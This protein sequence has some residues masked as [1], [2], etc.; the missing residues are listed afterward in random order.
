V[1]SFSVSTICVNLT[2]EARRRGVPQ[3][4]LECKPLKFNLRYRARLKAGR[5]SLQY[6]DCNRL[7]QTNSACNHQTEFGAAKKRNSPRYFAPLR[8][9]FIESAG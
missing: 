7:N 4:K 9:A 2:A 6:L 1:S 5:P 8:F 3:R